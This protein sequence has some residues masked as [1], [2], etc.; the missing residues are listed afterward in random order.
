VDLM[1][2]AAG[3]WVTSLEKSVMRP[4]PVFFHGGHVNMTNNSVVLLK[5]RIF[6]RT[7]LYGP[8]LPLERGELSI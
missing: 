2:L 7:I 8:K 4:A 3:P 1:L 6:G 5:S